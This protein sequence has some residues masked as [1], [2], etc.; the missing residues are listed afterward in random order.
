MMMVAGLAL[1]T[2][3]GGAASADA[4][5]FAH[6]GFCH[7][8]SGYGG[9]GDLPPAVF[10]ITV[11]HGVSEGSVD[12]ENFAVGASLILA[13]DCERRPVEGAK[14][15]SWQELSGPGSFL[16]RCPFRSYLETG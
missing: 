13:D 15:F 16:I 7:R 10:K 5:G 3:A 4:R 6:G 1:V 12:G 11:Q 14:L 2:L 9:F 8:E